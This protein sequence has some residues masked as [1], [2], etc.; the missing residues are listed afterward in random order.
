MKDKDRK[1]KD[2]AVSALKKVH[3]RLEKDGFEYNGKRDVPKPELLWKMEESDSNGIA[4]C[5]TN[6]VSNTFG[7]TWNWN[8]Q[9]KEKSFLRNRRPLTFGLR[10]D[11][12]YNIDKIVQRAREMKE[13]YENKKKREN[14]VKK[15]D[16][17]RRK[18]WNE[19]VSEHYPSADGHRAKDTASVCEVYWGTAPHCSG[20]LLELRIHDGDDPEDVQI[21]EF[22]VNRRS[23]NKVTSLDDDDLRELIGQ[24]TESVIED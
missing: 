18:M 2:K 11:D 22:S 5:V 17:S 14:K 8:I 10:K 13:E 20:V 9:V 24:F 6:T 3:E 19:Y 7:R 12:T 23:F 15:L 1:M 21:T 4:I 16:E